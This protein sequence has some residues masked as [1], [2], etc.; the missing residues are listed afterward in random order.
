MISFLRP[1]YPFRVNV[2]ELVKELKHA[3]NGGC[4]GPFGLPCMQYELQSLL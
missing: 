3:L 1:R 4:R 2:T